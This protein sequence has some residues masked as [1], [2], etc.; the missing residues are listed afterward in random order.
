MR[1][2]FIPAAIALALVGASCAADPSAKD[3]PAAV[4]AIEKAYKAFS[5]GQEKIL[6]EYQKLQQKK[7][8]K[9]EL[10]A[11]I[12]RYYTLSADEIPKLF[13]LAK[14]APR[15]QA[16]FQVF[17][18]VVMQGGDDAASAKEIFVEHHLDKPW[19]KQ[20]AQMLGQGFDPSAIELLEK[21][22]EKNPDREVQAWAELGMG[23]CHLK[24]IKSDAEKQAEHVERARTIL[25]EVGQKYADIEM[26]PGVTLAEYAVEQASKIDA[27]VAL[28]VGK[29]I[30][31]LEGEDTDG[32]KFKLSD[33]RGKVVL[34]D[35][36]AFW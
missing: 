35:F 30:I 27:N 33:Y 1:R 8:S 23:V 11:V 26:R 15:S 14:K 21:I 6:A 19:I 18:L 22:R 2:W 32:K 16:A 13:V 29:E 24:L 31:D 34:I 7:A 20:Y 36:W 9:E 10:Q 28:S 17:E 12:D 3:D 25:S 4:A 5:S